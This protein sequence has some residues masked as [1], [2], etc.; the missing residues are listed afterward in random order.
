MKTKMTNFDKRGH[1]NESKEVLELRD[2]RLLYYT[3]LTTALAEG[4]DEE[5]I[6]RLTAGKCR[7]AGLPEEPCVLRTVAQEH[8]TLNQDEVRKIFRA[9]YMNPKTRRQTPLTRQERIASEIEDG[10]FT[11]ADTSTNLAETKIL[12]IVH[13]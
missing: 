5:D 3:C 4:A 1:L 8:I 9:V 13:S 2:M 7:L 11:A 6:V 12:R 10:S